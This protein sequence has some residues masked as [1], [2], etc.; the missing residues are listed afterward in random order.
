VQVSPFAEQTYAVIGCAHMRYADQ[1][2]V[3]LALAVV[4][5][6]KPDYTIL[7]GDILDCKGLSKYAKDPTEVDILQE[8]IDMTRRFIRQVRRSMGITGLPAEDGRGRRIKYT[9]GNHETR[10][11]RYLQDNAP[12]LRSLTALSIPSLLEFDEH[13]V[14]FYRDEIVLAERNLVVHHGTMVRKGSGMSARAELEK[15]RFQVSSYSNHTHRMGVT[16]ATLPYSDRVLG[17][18]EGGCLHKLETE[19]VRHPDWQHGMGIIQVRGNEF[20]VAPLLFLGNEKARWTV[21]Q[22]QVIRA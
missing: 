15:R 18:W 1:A 19:Y 22:N 5:Y 20:R 9:M 8:E 14:E 10:L 11:E 13:D 6:V 7:N 21:Y 16:Y 17:G 12:A 4:E 2:A 3:E